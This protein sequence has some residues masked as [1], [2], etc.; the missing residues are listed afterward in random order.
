MGWWEELPPAEREQWERE[1]KTFCRDSLAYSNKT[2]Q[3]LRERR[4]E[5]ALE[6]ERLDEA[7]ENARFALVD[8]DKAIDGLEEHLADMTARMAEGA[9]A[10]LKGRQR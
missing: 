5:Q 4:E 8:T 9:G 7:L 1:F 10:F 6:V 2:L 3:E